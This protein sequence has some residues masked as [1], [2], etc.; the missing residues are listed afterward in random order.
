MSVWGLIPAVGK[1]TQKV[2]SMGE[3]T[4][5]SPAAAL[6]RVG[7][8]SHLDSTGDLTLVV[9]ARVSLPK[10][11]CRKAALPLVCCEVACIWGR[12]SA[13]FAP[14]HL[15]QSGELAPGSGERMSWPCPLPAA[16]LLRVGP[17]PHLTA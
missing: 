2:M 16:A 13:H 11:E 14:C 5:P 15:W 3:L 17:T 7:P 10:R 9:E 12:C 4:L 8:A 6:G 1:A